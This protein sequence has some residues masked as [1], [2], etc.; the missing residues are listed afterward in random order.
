[1]RKAR[2]KRKATNGTIHVIANCR[3]CDWSCERVETAR[4][5]GL[6]HAK[7]YGHLVSVEVGRAVT[8][9]YRAK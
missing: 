7:R 9:D 6:R 3:D 5:A 8:Y 1:M 4:A 2:E